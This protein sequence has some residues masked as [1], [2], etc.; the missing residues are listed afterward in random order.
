[1]F[2]SLT[3][4]QSVRKG[5]MKTSPKS[6][7]NLNL[8]A[9]KGRGLKG[10]ENLESHEWDLLFWRKICTIMTSRG[11]FCGHSSFLGPRSGS[12]AKASISLLPCPPT[13]TDGHPRSP[14]ISVQSGNDPCSWDVAA[15][16]KYDARC[17]PT[18]S[19]SSHCPRKPGGERAWTSHDAACATG[20]CAHCFFVY[21]PFSLFPF[22]FMSFSGQSFFRLWHINIG[23]HF[24]GDC[25]VLKGSRIQR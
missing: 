4:G 6:Q 24:E 23:L 25:S 11:G 8:F 16:F 20:G 17:S 3:V 22:C 19:M 12:M 18:F 13:G 2:S 1:M 5:D 10:K 15:L 14:L 7:C 9:K 21:S